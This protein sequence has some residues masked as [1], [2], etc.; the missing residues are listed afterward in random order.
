MQNDVLFSTSVSVLISK[1]IPLILDSDVSVRQAVV[2]VFESLLPRVPKSALLPFSGMICVFV[3]NGMTSINPSIR[4]SALLLL[5]SLLKIE[6]DLFKDHAKLLSSLV[7]LDIRSE[8]SCCPYSGRL[9][10]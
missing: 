6:P 3:N 2:N 1:T 7:K 5:Q 4:K 9:G 10:Q 8:N